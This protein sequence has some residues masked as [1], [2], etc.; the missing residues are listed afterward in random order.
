[1]A[2]VIPDSIKGALPLWKY[3]LP[4][5]RRYFKKV[6]SY[7]DVVIALSP[8][9]EEAVRALGVKTKIVKI[10]NPVLINKWKRTE[11]KRQQGRKLLNLSGD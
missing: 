3:L 8:M 1:T 10:Y 5:V 2:H 4:L 11:E 7:A 9:V 6:Y